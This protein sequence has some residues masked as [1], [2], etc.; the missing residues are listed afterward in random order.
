LPPVYFLAA[1]IL[2]VLLDRVLPMWRWHW[3]PGRWLGIALVVAG[4]SLT[5]ASARLFRRRKTAIKPFEQ[6]SVLV[7]EGPYRVSR[8]PMYV[9]LCTVLA[10]IG[11]LLESFA[12]LVV[13]PVFVGVIR[14]RF[15]AAEEQ[16]LAQQFG[17][18]YAEYRSRV[19]RWL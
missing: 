8:N 7:V 1:I 14:T 2:M 15:I 4:L 11:L 12:P 3:A 19:R 16:M 6:S 18:A 10:G 13:I 9:G 17:D 5:L